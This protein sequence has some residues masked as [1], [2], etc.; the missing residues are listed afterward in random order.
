VTEEAAPEQDSG[1]RSERESVSAATGTARSPR[2]AFRPRIVSSVIP[3]IIAI[4]AVA[5]ALVFTG[6]WRCPVRLATGYPCPGCGMTRAT[7]QALSGHF[8]EATAW[9][10]LVW[11][12]VPLIAA[13][14][15]VEI[16]CWIRTRSF[17][18]SKRIPGA[19]VVFYGTLAL[20]VV[21]WIARF[22]GALGGPCAPA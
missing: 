1:E 15:V 12:V 11:V 5:L 6:N 19:R 16:V 3:T 22:L 13:Y 18:A 20:I 10:P 17:G 2:G 7:L 9:H 14:F 8:R 21:V 4:A